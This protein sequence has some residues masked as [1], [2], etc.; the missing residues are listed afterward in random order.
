MNSKEAVERMSSEEGL[1]RLREIEDL[2]NSYEACPNT[3][4]LNKC[5]LPSKKKLKQEAK[6]I[7]EK[8][9][10]VFI[11]CGDEFYDNEE[12]CHCLEWCLCPSCKEKQEIKEIWE[13]IN[14]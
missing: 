6:E 7:Y 2:L 5:R 4:E 10:E 1:R 12:L 8:F 9:K 13:R 11:G 14:G 3:Y